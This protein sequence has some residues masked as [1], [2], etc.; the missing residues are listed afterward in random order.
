MICSKQHCGKPATCAPRI[1]I[2]AMGHPILP[3]K[4]CTIVVGMPM[5][6]GCLKDFDQDLILNDSLKASFRQ[7]FADIG[8]APPDFNRAFVVACKTDDPDFQN[9]HRKR[10]EREAAGKA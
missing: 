1:C 3:G 8:R 7:R 4:Q 6:D 2:P 10:A 5:C 9:I